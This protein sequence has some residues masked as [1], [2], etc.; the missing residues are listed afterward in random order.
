METAK[1]TETSRFK[2]FLVLGIIL[3]FIIAPWGVS[4]DGLTH[5]WKGS[6]QIQD[7]L[8]IYEDLSAGP[9]GASF[10]YLPPYGYLIR[11]WGL[12]YNLFN[13]NII[14]NPTRGLTDF[15]STSNILIYKSLLILCASLISLLLYKMAGLRAV[16]LWIFSPIIICFNISAGNMDLIPAVF[17]LLSIYSLQRRSFYFSVLLLALTISMKSWMAVLAPPFF[18]L[19]YQRASLKQVCTIAPAFIFFFY[20]PQLP[21]KIFISSQFDHHSF[22]QFL[23]LSNFYTA[24]LLGIVYLWG[25]GI[26]ITLVSYTILGLL[27][28]FRPPT[29]TSE[30]VIN[31]L[32]LFCLPILQAWQWNVAFLPLLALFA[33][34]K[35]KDISILAIYT[36]GI[37]GYL[38]CFWGGCHHFG[39]FPILYPFPWPSMP[40]YGDSALRY[41]ALWPL[42]CS[43]FFAGVII[44][45]YRLSSE[46]G[47]LRLNPNPTEDKDPHLFPALSAYILASVIVLLSCFWVAYKF[48]PY[49][50]ETYLSYTA[51][52][53]KEIQGDEQTVSNNIKEAQD[54]LRKNCYGVPIQTLSISIASRDAVE[55]KRQ[56]QA[57]GKRDLDLINQI[58][59]GT[60]RI[61]DTYAAGGDTTTLRVTAYQYNKHLDSVI[62]VSA[63]QEELDALVDSRRNYAAAVT[64]L[65]LFLILGMT[66]I[67]RQSCSNS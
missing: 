58:F 36:L 26:S 53:L 38:F 31:V 4:C 52:H 40:V 63:M 35:A 10:Y 41:T 48:L 5:M 20:L 59:Q 13:C 62:M 45:I 6:A 47:W 61:R 2:I 56:G 22:D 54:Y 43:F 14:W 33:S 16:A 51:Y 17:F 29:P 19:I 27:L 21:Y 46:I 50:L 55:D 18:Y 30:N 24:R 42:S 3:Y 28:I 9:C 7:F 12:L 67:L 25:F 39:G 44:L 34:R 8:H 66:W 15:T 23:S 11:G 60:D 37:T 32:L 65:S 1:R 49:N 57:P 64:I